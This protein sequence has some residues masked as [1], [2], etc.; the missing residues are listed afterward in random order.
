MYTAGKTATDERNL[1]RKT[2]QFEQHGMASLFSTESASLSD[3]LR[4]LPPDMW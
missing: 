2:E 4:S 3:T 1:Q